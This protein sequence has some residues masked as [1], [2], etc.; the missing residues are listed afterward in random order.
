MYSE[1]NAETKAELAVLSVSMHHIIIYMNLYSSS[2]NKNRR[3]KDER[4]DT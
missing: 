1:H 3:G 4:S 2:T